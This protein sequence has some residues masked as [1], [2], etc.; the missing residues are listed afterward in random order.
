MI[1]E[2]LQEKIEF[3]LNTLKENE[4]DEGFAVSF[5]GGRDS[6]VLKHL[7]QQTGLAAK[8]Y[9]LETT[10]E[11][12]MFKKFFE[13][14]HSDVIFIHPERTIYEMIKKNKCMPTLHNRFC[15]RERRLLKE[16]L[17]LN[18]ENC[19]VLGKRRSEGEYMK[20]RYTI[21]PVEIKENGYKILNPMY[22]WTDEDVAAYIQEYEI[23]ILETYELYGKSYNCS[24][25]PLHF[26]ETNQLIMKYHPETIAPM[27]EAC[28]YAWENN[29]TL[30]EEFPTK[31]DYWNWYIE[32][33]N[34]S[35]SIDKWNT[36]IAT[37]STD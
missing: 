37:L 30:H 14:Y 1:S 5:S 27:Q 15:C 13:D 32:Y 22:D 19:L 11:H 26:Y 34:V 35:Y 7:V 20:Q 18:A 3:A 10:L 12:D 2:T 29:E 25:C 36:H 23:P 6:C 24:I 31:E 16:A 21:E 8:Y 33:D 28:Y 9:Y 17:A 4:Y